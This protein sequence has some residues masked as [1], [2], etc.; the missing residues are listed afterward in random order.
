MVH[1]HYVMSDGVWCT[2]IM[3]RDASYRLQ[4]NYGHLID[5]GL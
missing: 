2:F 4:A 1:V 5:E 3:W